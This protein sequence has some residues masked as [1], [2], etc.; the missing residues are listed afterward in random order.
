MTTRG[1][2]WANGQIP[3]TDDD[4]L[5]AGRAAAG[6]TSSPEGQ[7]AALW[8]WAQRAA[9][10]A[11]GPGVVQCRGSEPKPV[12]FTWV[13]RCH[14]A[15]VSPYWLTQGDAARRARRARFQRATWSDLE[16]ESHGI[17]ERVYAWTRGEY[18]NPIPGLVDFSEIGF[19]DVPP[20]AIEIGGNA[21]FRSGAPVITLGGASG[22]STIAKAMLA[23]GGAL[24]VAFA[25]SSLME[26]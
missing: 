20:G 26:D 9:W 4:L 5:W 3:M 16:R 2:S 25:V 6:E 22:T 11:E 14:S 21:F 24:A 15:V 23:V 12:T 13:V 1:I 8:A 19:R 17:Q 10:I 18:R 7:I